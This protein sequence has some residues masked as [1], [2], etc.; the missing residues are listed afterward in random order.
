MS[1]TSTRPTSQPW[2][3]D[4]I[5]TGIAYHEFAHVLQF[6]NP[7]ATDAAVA[8]F[9]G[10]VETMADC[11]SL[12]YLLGWT[13]DHTVWVSSFEVLGGERRVRLAPA[14]RPS[15]R[16]S[17]TGSARSATRAARSPSSG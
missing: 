10:D 3:T 5:Q 2:M 15:S 14:T 8:A 16:R 12:T 11:Y 13:L 4:F 6:T 17:G 9:G 1:C 7:E